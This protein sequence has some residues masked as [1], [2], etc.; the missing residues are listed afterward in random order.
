[1]A[2]RVGVGIIGTGTIAQWHLRA[3]QQ[4]PH[5]QAVAVFDV[6]SERAQTTA[7]A[8]GIPFVARSLEEL[9]SRPE[10]ETVIVATPPAATTRPP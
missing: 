1:M 8:F 9:L 7:R 2:G 5:G 10:V 6:L 4:S 3:L